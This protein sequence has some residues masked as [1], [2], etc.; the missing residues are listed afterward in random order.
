[1]NIIGQY[2][3][4]SGKTRMIHFERLT[5]I[6]EP[7]APLDIVTDTESIVYRGELP[8]ILEFVHQED[9]TLLSQTLAIDDKS[10]MIGL[11]CDSPKYGQIY[12]PVFDSKLIDD[13]DI[14]DPN[15]IPPI[16]SNISSELERYIHAKNVAK[17]LKGYTLWLYS[18][19]GSLDENDIIVDNDFF[20]S[21]Q[22]ILD[23]NYRLYN[24]CP[25]LENGKLRVPNTATK[26]RLLNYLRVNLG[27][28]KGGVELYSKYS[29][30]PPYINFK[31]NT[32]FI[33]DSDTFFFSK[34][35]HIKSWVQSKQT[36]K[37]HSTIY[38]S[39][40]VN[41][42]DMIEEKKYMTEVQ[43]KKHGIKDKFRAIKHSY[44]YRN[45]FIFDYN[46]AIIQPVLDNDLKR[47][48]AVSYKWHNDHIN[49]G[50]DSEPLDTDVSYTV[51]NEMGEKQYVSHQGDPKSVTVILFAE[52][53]YVALL[54]L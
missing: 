30:I 11:W 8:H 28:D 27:V 10:T 21:E 7:M 45:P 19:N 54:K 5:I 47:A 44:F 26:D 37:I 32:D 22:H 42:Y 43:L 50:Y 34:R 16:L 29:Q 48:I 49:I 35:A 53:K 36:K 41:E 1:M 39:V 25:L 6:T 51:Y 3:D 9:A 31:D 24:D 40:H 17:L 20:I 2:I 15:I 33:Q 14:T 52:D 13:L 46:I 23:I 12:I 4:N 38:S 18:K